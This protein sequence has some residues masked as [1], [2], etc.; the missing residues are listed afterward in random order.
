MRYYLPIY[1]FDCK[2]R[3]HFLQYIRS[4]TG[5]I[6]RDQHFTVVVLL[7]TSDAESSGDETTC[8]VGIVNPNNSVVTAT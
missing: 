7:K 1:S 3:R 5:T 2:S 6:R 8:I 4:I